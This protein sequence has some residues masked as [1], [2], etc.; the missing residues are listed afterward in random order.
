LLGVT[1]LLL[2]ETVARRAV[3]DYKCCLAFRAYAHGGLIGIA[4][5]RPHS[6]ISRNNTKDR[7]QECPHHTWRIWSSILSE[8]NY[9]YEC[10]VSGR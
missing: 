1:I 4:N 8:D 9:D 5:R 2:V 3:S 6:G 7:G 10:A